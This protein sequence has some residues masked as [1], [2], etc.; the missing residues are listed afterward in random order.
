M[1]YVDYLLTFDCSIVKPAG[2]LMTVVG[3]YNTK[4]RSCKYVR[5]ASRRVRGLALQSRPAS[6]RKPVLVSYYK[7]NFDIFLICPIKELK[8]QLGS[9][10]SSSGLI[11][12]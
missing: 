10:K 3:A 5:G 7:H 12:V 4:V 9:M 2:K 6:E 1:K 8:D 11:Q